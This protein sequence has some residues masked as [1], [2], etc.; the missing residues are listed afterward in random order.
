MIQIIIHIKYLAQDS[1]A[2]NGSSSFIKWEKPK[3]KP[4]R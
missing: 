2:I 1:Y 4:H 3:N